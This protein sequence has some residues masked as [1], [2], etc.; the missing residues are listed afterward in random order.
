MTKND[1]LNHLKEV[2]RDLQLAKNYGE[3]NANNAIVNF[4]KE[5]LDKNYDDSL[6]GI[7]DD[8]YHLALTFESISSYSQQGHWKSVMSTQ[9]GWMIGRWKEE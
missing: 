6:K 7:K 4:Y 9:I 3:V 5:N 1:V 8:F 2:Q